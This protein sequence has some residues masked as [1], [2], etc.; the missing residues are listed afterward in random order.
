M[1]ASNAAG[2]R[3]PAEAHKDSEP[4]PGAAQIGRPLTIAAQ[5]PLLDMP[6]RS[7]TSLST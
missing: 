1:V 3:V 5:T 2:E 4:A 7:C 6:L